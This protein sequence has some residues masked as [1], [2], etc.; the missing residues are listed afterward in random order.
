MIATLNLLAALLVPGEPPPLSDDQLTR[1][2]TLVKTH[3]EEQRTF[4]ADLDAAQRK[5]AACYARYE[6][7]EDEAKSLQDEVL[8]VQGKLL[9]S[10]HAMQKELRA[11]VGPERF[12]VLSARIDNALR[13]PPQPKP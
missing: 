11:I 10:Y 1:V 5:L 13:H 4:K 7:D 6:L 12:K 9:R 8:A 3:Q 2:R